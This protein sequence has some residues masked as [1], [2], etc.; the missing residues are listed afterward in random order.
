MQKG[1][2]F[3]DSHSP[4]AK[5]FYA[6]YLFTTTRH[7]VPAKELQRQLGV[8]SYPPAFRMAHLIRDYMAKIDGNSGLSG[9]V[10]IDETFVG[11]RRKTGRRMGRGTL[12]K[13]SCLECWSGTAM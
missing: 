3:G 12:A 13:P 9:E 2:I 5:W 4:L 6:M 10:E 7:G 11:G 8:K 1:T